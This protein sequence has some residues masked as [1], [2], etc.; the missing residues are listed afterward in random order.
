MD[1]RGDVIFGINICENNL[2]N[3]WY[4]KILSIKGQSEFISKLTNTIRFFI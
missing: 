4:G 2:D 1:K 3:F